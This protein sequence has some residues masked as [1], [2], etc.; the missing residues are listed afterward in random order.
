MIIDLRTYTMVPGRL[1]AFLTLY[2]AEGLP[3]QACHQGQ[4]VGYFVTEIGANNQVVHLWRYDSMGD[5]ETRR[6]ALA[7][8]PGWIA[9]RAKSAAEG[10]VQ[11]QENKI[12]RPTSFSPL[13]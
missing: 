6:A 8:D 4:P 10:N 12:I 7:K 13:K 3:V 9:Y 2:Q 1:Q 11:F 5:R